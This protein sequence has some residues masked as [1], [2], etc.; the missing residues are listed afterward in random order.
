MSLTV[1]AFSGNQSTK[2]TLWD[3]GIGAG[4]ENY[5]GHALDNYNG[6]EYFKLEFSQAVTLTDVARGWV[7][8]DG[9]LEIGTNLGSLT[10]YD[11]G[12]TFPSLTGASNL[13]YISAAN[14]TC[15]SNRTRDC[16]YVKVKSVTVSSVPLPAAVWL[17]GS[18]LIGLVGVGYKRAESTL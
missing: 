17:F 8:N 7:S 18:A 9:D 15:R 3:G 2:V 11:N 14:D 1:S 12:T 5:P 10:A 4:G 16:D 6:V 13:W